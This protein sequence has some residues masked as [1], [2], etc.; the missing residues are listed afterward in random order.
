M[1][2]EHALASFK[3]AWKLTL[4]RYHGKQK[5]KLQRKWIVDIFAHP[6]KLMDYLKTATLPEG[7]HFNMHS[8]A[9]SHLA[10]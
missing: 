4:K 8:C 10:C 7:R 2:A 5:L 6:E 9:N 3:L 1:E